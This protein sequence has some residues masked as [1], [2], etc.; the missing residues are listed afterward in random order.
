[1]TIYYYF[2]TALWVDQE[3]PTL[4]MLWL[5]AGMCRRCKEN[6]HT[7][8]EIGTGCWRGA[9]LELARGPRFFSNTVGSSALLF[10]RSRSMVD[11][12]QNEAFQEDKA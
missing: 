8:P 9:H 1:M 10:M 2:L 3:V 7:W 6:S 12:F 4:H 5:R 11:R